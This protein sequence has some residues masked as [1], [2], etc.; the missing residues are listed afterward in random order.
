MTKFILLLL[1]FCKS[2]VYVV[3]LQVMRGLSPSWR[4]AACEGTNSVRRYIKPGYFDRTE[5]NPKWSKFYVMDVGRSMV[6]AV[7]RDI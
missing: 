3:F 2:K 7:M 6:T 1:P 5:G 4:G